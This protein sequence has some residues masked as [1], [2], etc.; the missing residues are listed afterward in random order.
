MKEPVRDAGKALQ[1]ILLSGNFLGSLIE[2][3]FALTIPC[4]SHTLLS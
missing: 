2:V 4:V 1:R 3:S